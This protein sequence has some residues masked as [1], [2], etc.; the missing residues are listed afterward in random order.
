MNWFSELSVLRDWPPLALPFAVAI[1]GELVLAGL[2]IRSC[3]DR[4][5]LLIS[6]ILLPLH[7]LM[8]LLVFHPPWEFFIEIYVFS[9]P[10]LALGLIVYLIC[11]CRRKRMNRYL[12]T[13]ATVW[14]LYFASVV[15]L[16]VFTVLM[17]QAFRR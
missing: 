3:E 16:V 9:A 7:V 17:A 13:A 5:R 6:A 4:K 2:M 8:Y 10:V 14:A 1:V 15:F 11:L 12:W